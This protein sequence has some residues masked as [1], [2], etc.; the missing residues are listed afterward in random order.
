[1]A[2]LLNT[3]KPKD[4][5]H[6]PWQWILRRS[7]WKPLSKETTVKCVKQQV[8]QLLHSRPHNL[9][10]SEY[11]HMLTV[12]RTV[13]PPTDFRNFFRKAEPNLLQRF[14]LQ[15]PYSLPMKIPLLTREGK[16][17]VH[18]ICNT[19]IPALTVP[20]PLRVYLQ[21]AVSVRNRPHAVTQTGME[22]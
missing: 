13:L 4:A 3:I 7:A 19:V 22:S 1:M 21:W 15:L 20:D 5:R 8:H 11:L 18:E 12:A 16:A 6:K 9:P 17:A 10:L 2:S 14:K